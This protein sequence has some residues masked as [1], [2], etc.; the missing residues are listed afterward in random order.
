MDGI[1]SFVYSY[2]SLIAIMLVTPGA[3]KLIALCVYYSRLSKHHHS[4]AYV[5]PPNEVCAYCKLAPGIDM[6]C[7]I[8]MCIN[9]Y[10]I[11]Y[12]TGAI[13][14]MAIYYWVLVGIFQSLSI[15]IVAMKICSTS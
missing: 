2:A 3:L 1:D 4:E 10:T 12:T 9:V 13:A 8:I 15:L 7:L 11:L 6:A 5:I 14:E